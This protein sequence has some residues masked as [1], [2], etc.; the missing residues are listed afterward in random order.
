M[1]PEEAA[2]ILNGQEYG[3]K[4]TTGNSALFASM[5]RE[6]LVAVFGESDDVMAFEGAIHD[7]IGAYNGGTAYIDNNGLLVNDCSNDDCPHFA[8]RKERAATIEAVWCPD[9]TMSWA[10]KTDITHATFDIMEDDNV[11]CRGIVFR[12]SDVRTK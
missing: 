6:G 8:A 2:S 12:L 9:D 11:F 3:L 10:F 4:F 1:T 7:E 5:K